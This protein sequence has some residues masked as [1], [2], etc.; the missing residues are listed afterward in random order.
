MAQKN[1]V[2]VDPWSIFFCRSFRRAFFSVSSPFWQ[3]FFWSGFPLLSFLRSNFLP[4]IVRRDERRDTRIRSERNE[5]V[6]VRVDRR[7]EMNEPTEPGVVERMHFS[8]FFY[9]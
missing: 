2:L 4:V 7:A 8:F 6:Q 5:R 3:I 1:T 9:E